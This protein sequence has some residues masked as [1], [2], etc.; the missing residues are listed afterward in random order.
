MR[1][2]GGSFGRARTESRGA[3]RASGVRIPLL[4]DPDDIPAVGLGASRASDVSF[5]V[6]HRPGKKARQDVKQNRWRSIRQASLALLQLPR[7]SPRR[8]PRTSPRAMVASIPEWREKH[9]ADMSYAA[10]YSDAYP[11]LPQA[12]V[13][14]ATA[15]RLRRKIRAARRAERNGPAAPAERTTEPVNWPA[16]RDFKEAERAHETRDDVYRADHAGAHA[17]APRMARTRRRRPDAVP[18]ARTCRNFDRSRH[19]PPPRPPPRPRP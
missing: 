3:P 13:S 4:L 1:T 12:A 5:G 16:V 7:V 11:D 10:T 2:N 8:A 6:L 18:I 19:P 14:D 9:P 15:R 17:L